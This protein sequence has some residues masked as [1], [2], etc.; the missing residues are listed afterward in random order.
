MQSTLKLLAFAQPSGVGDAIKSWFWLFNL[1][2]EA[3]QIVIAKNLHASA[4][5][6]IAKSRA[7][8]RHQLQVITS[9]HSSILY[10]G[11]G[12]ITALW[13]GSPSRSKKGGLSWSYSISHIIDKTKT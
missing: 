13:I 12:W 3:N 5:S 1:F 6:D 10:S 7:L 8:L 4:F 9:S 2:L 11:R